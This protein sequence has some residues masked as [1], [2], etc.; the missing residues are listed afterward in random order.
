MDNPTEIVSNAVDFSGN[1]ELN[2]TAFQAADEELENEPI[3]VS[4]DREVNGLDLGDFYIEGDESF[5]ANKINEFINTLGYSD[6]LLGLKAETGGRNTVVLK[7]EG[8]NS[9]YTFYLAE[10]KESVGINGIT[11]NIKKV[12]AAQLKKNTAKRAAIGSFLDVQQVGAAPSST[13]GK[14]T[15]ISK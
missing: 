10:S 11:K 9:L 7:D 2:N 12:V 4:I 8:G 14:K 3:G 5:S 13:R 15:P 1:S 6:L